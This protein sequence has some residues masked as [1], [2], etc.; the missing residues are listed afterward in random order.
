MG[1]EFDQAQQFFGFGSGRAVGQGGDHRQDLGEHSDGPARV[2]VG[3]GRA[4]DLAATEV[5]MGVGLS[6]PT[7]FERAQ[8]RCVGQLSVDQ[9]HQM[10]PGSKRFVVSVGAEARDDRL[11]APPIEGLDEPAENGRSKAHVPQPFLKS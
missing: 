9:S 6:V 3:E 5:I 7:G 11:E 4:R 10:I 1:V 8:G 2:G